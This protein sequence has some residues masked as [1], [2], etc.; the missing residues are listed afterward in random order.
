M[1]DTL[2]GLHAES[3]QHFAV[4]SFRRKRCIDA[5]KLSGW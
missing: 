3:L 2:L 1:T 4:I 5:T